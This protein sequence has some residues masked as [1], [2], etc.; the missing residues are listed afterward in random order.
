MTGFGRAVNEE[1]GDRVEVEIRSVNGKQLDVRFSLPN[2]FSQLEYDFRRR[3]QAKVQRGA[4]S[5]NLKFQP[6]PER[7]AAGLRIDEDLAAEAVHRL[8]KLA[9]RL[10]L[11]QTITLAQIL[12]LPGIVAL[13]DAAAVDENVAQLA[14]RTLDE[15][16]EALMTMRAREA[17]TLKNQ[18]V[19]EIK[20]MLAAAARIRD[21]AD[22][23]LQNWRDH[24]RQQIAKL[25]VE[26]SLDD[27]LLAR[28]LAFHAER[29]DVGEEL[30]RIFSHLAEFQRRLETAGPVG[31]T[32]MFLCQELGREINTLAAKTR[33]SDSAG[34]IL[35]LKRLLGKIKEQSANI[36]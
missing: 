31:R 9:R 35:E 2:G 8:R 10:Q 30:T 15:A 4:L 1:H 19:V 11:P 27:Q 29:S 14:R 33:D 25:G 32:L 20:A 28:E 24:L 23:V 34:D 17:E 36:E 7:T 6:S 3:I 13:E 18:M 26:V 5:V 16:L 21:R 12:E 22:A